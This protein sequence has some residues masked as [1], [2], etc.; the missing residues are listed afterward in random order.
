MKIGRQKELDSMRNAEKRNAKAWQFH[1]LSFLS[2]L[3]TAERIQR[4]TLWE[5]D[6]NQKNRKKTGLRLFKTSVAF[7]KFKK[8]GRRTTAATRHCWVFRPAE[9]TQFG[10]ILFRFDFFSKLAATDV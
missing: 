10:K 4:S 5:A 1:L 7:F 8:N 9:S 2:N 6:E 3:F